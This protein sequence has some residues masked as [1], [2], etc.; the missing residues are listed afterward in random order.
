MVATLIGLGL[1]YLTYWLRVNRSH[2]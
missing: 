1:M 2:A